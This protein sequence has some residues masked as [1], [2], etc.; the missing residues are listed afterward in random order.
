MVIVVF[1]V[2]LNE[3]KTEEYLEIAGELK[4][5]LEK[6]PGFIRAERFKSIVQDRKILSMSIWEDDRAL[7]AWRT[8]E[9]HRLGQ[10]KGRN[11]IFES[12]RITVTE[13]IRSYTESDRAEAPV[14]S[15]EYFGLTE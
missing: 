8:L 12:Y 11:G 13:A 3:G 2:V 15:N 9:K 1:E 10:L 4:T 6:M 5:Y 7:E 14:D